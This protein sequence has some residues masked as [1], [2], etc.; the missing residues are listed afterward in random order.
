MLK[1]IN[2]S[3]NLFVVIYYFCFMRIELSNGEI[4]KVQTS[5]MQARETPVLQ[6]ILLLLSTKMRNFDNDNGGRI[7]SVID[8]YNKIIEEFFEMEDGKVRERDV[9]KEDGGVQVIDRRERV[10]KDG[11]SDDGFKAA[12]DTFLA[13]KNYLDI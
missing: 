2:N 10:T 9:F 8:G 1:T 3:C 12:I 11:K 6:G 7:R 4:M 5:L 13:K